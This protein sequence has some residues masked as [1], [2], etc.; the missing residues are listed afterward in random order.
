MRNGANIA[1]ARHAI[2]VA[3]LYLPAAHRD[4]LTQRARMYHGLYAIEIAQQMI[5]R[6][7]WA[8][9]RAQV[10]EAF[11]CAVSPR[12]VLA[13]AQLA[14]HAVWA[15]TRRTPALAETSKLT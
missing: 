9:A 13:T 14:F 4:E 10:R 11:R 5:V 12:I 6:R 3:R 1:D 15:L 8:S 7:S 2:D